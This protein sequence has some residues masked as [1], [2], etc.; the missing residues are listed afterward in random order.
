MDAFVSLNF[1][2]VE[3]HNDDLLVTFFFKIE[4]SLQKIRTM[5]KKCLN[6]EVLTNGAF[7]YKF[8]IEICSFCSLFNLN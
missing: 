8:R 2:R 4:F 3:I 1:Q 6:F 5:N 7:L